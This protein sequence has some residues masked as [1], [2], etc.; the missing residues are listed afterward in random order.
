MCTPLALLIQLERCEILLNLYKTKRVLGDTCDEF[1][2]IVFCASRRQSIIVGRVN[3]FRTRCHC[4]VQYVHSGPKVLGVSGSAQV[5]GSLTRS[6]PYVTL[7]MKHGLQDLG[8][9][10]VNAPR[11]QLVSG[12]LRFETRGA[13]AKEGGL[14]R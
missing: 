6:T 12:M 5:E 14:Q 9:A 1:R 3:S 13:A 2:K 8:D 4:L 10:P 7:N 11:G